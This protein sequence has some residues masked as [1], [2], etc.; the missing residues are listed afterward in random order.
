MFSLLNRTHLNGKSFKKERKQNK[1]LKPK[2][3]FILLFVLGFCLAQEVG[4]FASVATLPVSAASAPSATVVQGSA[5]STD[6]LQR[7]KALY[8]AGKF[9]EAATVL[10][11]AVTTFKS[12]GNVL[13]QA[14]ALSNLALAYQHL[15][16][17]SE[18]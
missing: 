2:T 18:A 8:D 16:S 17:W 7:G 1:R 10:Q 15:G 14:T 12:E 5:N 4:W 6:L 9:S 13:R 3:L 11:Q